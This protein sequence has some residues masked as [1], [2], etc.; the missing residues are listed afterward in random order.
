MLGL[1]LSLWEGSGGYMQACNVASNTTQHFFPSHTIVTHWYHSTRYLT[2]PQIMKIPYRI[3]VRDAVPHHTKHYTSRCTTTHHN[4]PFHSV[5]HS[6]ILN[7]TV[8]H[9]IT[10]SY[11]TVSHHT[12]KYQTS[13][14]YT[15]SSYS[16]TSYY[17]S[18]P[19]QDYITCVLSNLNHNC[20]M[21]SG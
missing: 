20:S 15:A 13:P 9:H 3:V 19:A 16:T 1:W 17:I 12:A 4:T 18:L 5:R 6:S 11:L 14:H 8:S 10:I 7:H 21:Y 2:T